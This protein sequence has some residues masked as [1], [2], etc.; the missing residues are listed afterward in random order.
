MAAGAI[1]DVVLE[2]GVDADHDV[3]GIGVAGVVQ[4][5]ELDRRLAERLHVVAPA[6]ALK[7]VEAALPLGQQLGGDE[8]AQRDA[9]I[10][11]PGG[12]DIGEQADGAVA[13]AVGGPLG[14]GLRR[15]GGGE[16][17]A[18]LAAR[19]PAGP[20]GMLGGPGAPPV[21]HVRRHAG[22]EEPRQRE[23][24]EHQR[25]EP[26]AEHG[27]V[28]QQVDDDVQGEA[29]A[30]AAAASATTAAEAARAA[31]GGRERPGGDEQRQRRHGEEDEDRAAPAG[32]HQATASASGPRPG[33]SWAMCWSAW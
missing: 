6:A 26:V 32:A 20:A 14:V 5:H 23:R 18:A 22:D 16:L 17:D 11:V 31:A 10:G 29:A 12:L 1:D 21:A 19:R 13:D 2:P 27:D 33:S 25:A 9:V 15:L 7:V 4:P 28:D 24:D 30:V 3:I 8:P